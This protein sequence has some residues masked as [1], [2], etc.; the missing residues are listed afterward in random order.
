MRDQAL[1]VELAAPLA[2]FQ[3]TLSVVFVQSEEP[4]GTGTGFFDLLNHIGARFRQ[5]RFAGIGSSVAG[6]GAGLF[7]KLSC[8]MPMSTDASR[9][10]TNVT[11]TVSLKNSPRLISLRLS[12][13][14]CRK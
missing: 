1:I 2:F 11:R 8:A 12:F 4:F 10:A 14:E 9:G 6:E 13:S 5:F 7:V 3:G